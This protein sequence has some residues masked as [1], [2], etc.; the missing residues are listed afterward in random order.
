[1][2]GAGSRGGQYFLVCLIGALL[3]GVTRGSPLPERQD[4]EGSMDTDRVSSLAATTP[5]EGS[6]STT[7]T[8]TEYPYAAIAKLY[9]KPPDKV[10]T[11]AYSSGVYKFRIGP[12]EDEQKRLLEEYHYHFERVEKN[13]PPTTKRYNFAPPNKY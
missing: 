13:L 8:T 12:E 7:T 6:T 4:V 2:A 11:I 9:A 1:M 5:T 3:I 10:G